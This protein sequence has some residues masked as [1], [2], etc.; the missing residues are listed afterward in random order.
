M[1]GSHAMDTGIDALAAYIRRYA[2]SAGYDLAAW[3]E[4]A[5]LARDAEM[6]SGTL[7]RILTGQRMPKPDK[8]WPLAKALGRPYP[9]LLVESQIIPADSLAHMAQPAVPSLP[10]TAEVLADQWGVRD[11][12]GRELVQDM[13][14]RLRM[15]AQQPPGDQP[16]DH[17]SAEA[18][19]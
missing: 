14:D 2:P 17:G 18:H 6:D 4:Q 9:E 15:L 13:L 7:A 3:G 12:K 8:L 11:A 1:T 5:R 16:E 10:I 19:G